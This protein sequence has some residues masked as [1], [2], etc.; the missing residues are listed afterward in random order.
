MRRWTEIFTNACMFFGVVFSCINTNTNAI[1]CMFWEWFD[2]HWNRLSLGGSGE[3]KPTLNG[4]D[5]SVPVYWIKSVQAMTLFTNRGAFWCWNI[6]VRI[7]RLFEY[8]SW[9]ILC[10]NLITKSLES[11]SRHTTDYMWQ[12]QLRKRIQQIDSD[13][14]HTS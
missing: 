8:F 7:W 11:K 13:S 9:E 10:E 4:L 6:N 14:T 2:I 12:A 5:Y 3:L 1:A